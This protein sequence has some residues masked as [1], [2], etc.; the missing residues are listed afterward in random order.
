MSI[1]YEKILPYDNP[2]VS[3]C[4]SMDLI[5]VISS[6]EKVVEVHRCGYKH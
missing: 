2:F 3:W 5:G 6:T 1:L 4:I